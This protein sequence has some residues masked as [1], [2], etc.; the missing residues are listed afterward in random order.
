MGK[1]K[2]QMTDIYHV[3]NTRIRV[4]FLLCILHLSCGYKL[5]N[6]DINWNVFFMFLC[7]YKYGTLALASG[8]GQFVVQIGIVNMNMWNVTCLRGNFNTFTDGSKET[9]QYIY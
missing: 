9:N 1:G 2:K 8:E 7:F 4:I 5:I 3:H 6:S